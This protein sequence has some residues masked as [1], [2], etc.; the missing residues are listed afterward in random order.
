M[1]LIVKKSTDLFTYLLENT[2][3]TKTRLMEKF[4]YLMMCL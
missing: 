4:P 2:D 3:Y 1:K